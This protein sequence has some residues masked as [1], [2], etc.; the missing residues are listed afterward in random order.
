MTYPLS[1]GNSNFQDPGTTLSDGAVRYH[2]A[3]FSIHDRPDWTNAV[4]AFMTGTGTILYIGKASSLSDR[5]CNHERMDEALRRGAE[6]LLVH[7]PGATA[8]FPYEQ[9][10]KRLINALSPTMNTHHN[11]L[12]GVLSGLGIAPAQPDALGLGLINR[13]SS[14]TSAWTNALGLI[15]TTPSPASELAAALGLAS[16][17]GASVPVGN[18][19]GLNPLGAFMDTLEPKPVTP[20]NNALADLMRTLEPDPN[21]FGFGG[22]LPR[23]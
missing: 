15:N 17:M 10:E 18:A 4:Y 14:N 23:T 8:Q 11:A 6:Y 19:F 1:A 9:A 21:P 7:R 20:S 22:I 12:A 3:V 5:L 16:G 2:F 13:T